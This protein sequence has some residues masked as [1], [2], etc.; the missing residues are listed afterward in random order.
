[1]ACDA[2]IIFL[3]ML[4]DGGGR[5]EIQLLGTVYDNQGACEKTGLAPSNDS[6]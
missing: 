2:G 6:R 5:P 3:T 1:M 4:S